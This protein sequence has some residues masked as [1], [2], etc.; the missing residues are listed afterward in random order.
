MFR[1]FYI[2]KF[3]NLFIIS[4]NLVK[5]RERFAMFSIKCCVKKLK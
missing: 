1:Y 5:Y 4:G 2:A 3:I